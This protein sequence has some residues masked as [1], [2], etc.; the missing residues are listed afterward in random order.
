MRKIG[1]PLAPFILA[2]V[3]AELLESN[4]RRLLLLSDGDY[5]F[6]FSQPIA[7]VL[8]A[9]AALSLWVA[10]RRRHARSHF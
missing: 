7:D 5:L 8:L 2:M 6:I 1:M 9:L 10:W 3:L 4:F